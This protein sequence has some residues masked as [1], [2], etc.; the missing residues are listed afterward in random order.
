MCI[1]DRLNALLSTKV[2]E[3]IPMC[4]QPPAIAGVGSANGVTF[5]LEDLSLIHI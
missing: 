2:P 4:F 5:M 3:G 1:R